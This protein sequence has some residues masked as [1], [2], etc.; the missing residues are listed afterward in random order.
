M[1]FRQKDF[2]IYSVFVY[3][4]LLLL[5]FLLR[6]KQ[7]FKDVCYG[8]YGCVRFCCHDIDNCN[9]KFIKE[10][11]N[12]SLLPPPYM[13]VSAEDQK[14]R[15]DYRILYGSPTCNLELNPPGMSWE[16]TMVS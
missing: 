2:V 7:S 3:I 10:H 16:F 14:T 8:R 13:Y 9:E 4:L 15:T 11:F 1:N 5:V 6:D 12:A